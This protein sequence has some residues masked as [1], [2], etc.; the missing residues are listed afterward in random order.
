MPCRVPDGSLRVQDPN[1]AMRRGQIAVALEALFEYFD[2][3]GA[4]HRLEHEEP[5][6]AFGDEH[7]LAV[8]RPVARAL[9]QT[10]RHQERGLY[11]D[12][13]VFLDFSAN[14]ILDDTVDSPT[15]GVP[16]NLTR[17]FVVDMEEV[18]FTAD[19]AVVALFRFDEHIEISLEVVRFFPGG[20]IDAGKH[21]AL[22]VPSPVCA[23][24]LH[25][26][27]ALDIEFLRARDMWAAAEV[28]KVTGLDR[29][30]LRHQRGD[31]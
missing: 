17:I 15:I 23:G 11:F 7:V 5:F 1:S 24:G 14:V 28:G 3:A 30:R 19:L 9:P 6:F 25:Q 10:L 18:E 12:I 13:T 21:R 31:R 29:G 4:V 26:L 20:S 22:F 2:M 16:E 27:E 8:F